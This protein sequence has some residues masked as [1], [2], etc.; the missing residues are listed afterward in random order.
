MDY[1]LLL[2]IEENPKHRQHSEFIRRISKK[3][4]SFNAE[5]KT[6]E[7]HSF[8][9]ELTPNNR[10]KTVT[11]QNPFKDFEGKRHMFLSSNMMYIYHV[12]IIDYLQNYNLDK[13]MEH[14]VK[15]ILRGRKSEISAVPP[16]R[17][18]KRYIEFM[19]NQVFIV[20]KKSLSAEERSDTMDEH[21][22]EA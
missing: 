1:S 4:H 5:P 11:L 10:N 17:Y 14:L 3:A 6:E 22:S 12:A 13:K 16:E 8:D 21:K 19:E 9:R 7:L 2:A 20:D 18:S 15:T